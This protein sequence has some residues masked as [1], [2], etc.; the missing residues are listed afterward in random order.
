MNDISTL[1]GA[2]GFAALS[3]LVAFLM[4]FDVMNG[5]QAAMTILPASAVMAFVAF[6][7][8]RL[9]ANRA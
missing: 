9:D 3:I 1:S 4:L 5:T 6:R 2:A 7:A 8:R